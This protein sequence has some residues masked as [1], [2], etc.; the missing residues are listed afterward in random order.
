MELPRCHIVCPED[1]FELKYK[2]QAVCHYIQEN[3]KHIL[4]RATSNFLVNSRNVLGVTLTIKL[5][6]Y[7]SIITVILYKIRRVDYLT[8]NENILKRTGLL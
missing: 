3:E 4:I 1:H 6:C 7:F 8:D 5:L 2:L